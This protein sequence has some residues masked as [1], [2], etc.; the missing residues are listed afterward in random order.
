MQTTVTIEG[1]VLPLRATPLAKL[2]RARPMLDKGAETEEG[3]TAL[4]EALFH[5]IRRAKGDVTLDWLIENIDVHNAPE[6]FAKFAEVNG[7]TEKVAE[8]TMVGEAQA[9]QTS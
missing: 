2:V 3:V 6:V 4:A 8:A 1:I 7:M 9:G 5:G